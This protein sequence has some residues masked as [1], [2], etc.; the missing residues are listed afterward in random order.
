[1]TWEELDNK[2][3]I[4][5]LWGQD[6]NQNSHITIWEN[7]D[8]ISDLTERQKAALYITTCI[9]N[10]KYSVVCF[11]GRGFN[12]ELKHELGTFRSLP[13]LT[14]VEIIDREH[15]KSTTDEDLILYA[16]TLM[17]FSDLKI[18]D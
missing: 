11:F 3:N 8:F 7:K 18:Q 9:S 1:M 14:R 6:S 12:A 5:K 17:A 2:H 16:N 15:F 4:K 13:I 10:D